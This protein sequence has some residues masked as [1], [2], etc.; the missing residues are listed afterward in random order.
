M[1]MSKQSSSMSRRV[2]IAGLGV[3][4]LGVMIAATTP[5]ASAQDAAEAM[6][7]HPIVG[8]WQAVTPAGPAPAIFFPNGTV[9]IS[10]PVT[11]AGPNGVVYVSSQP[12]TWEPV[13]DRGIHFTGVQLHSDANGTYTGSVTIDGYP[14]VSEDGQ[15][16]LDDQSL[17]KITIRDAA[18]VI[19]Q[20]MPAAGAPPVTGRRMG[21]DSP[22]FAADSDATPSA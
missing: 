18:G 12:G 3:S 22:G 5:T 8:A 21:V 19:L 9:L 6:A 13:S 15:M 14:V 16:I 20:Q 11:Q 4:G 10:V 1:S 7:S 17:G 2:A